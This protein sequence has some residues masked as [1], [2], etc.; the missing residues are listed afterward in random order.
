M[1]KKQEAKLSSMSYEIEYMLIK[2]LQETHQH[3]K[4]LNYKPFLLP[5]LKFSTFFKFSTINTYCL[6]SKKINILKQQVLK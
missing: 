5:S 3:V 4:A 6:Y 1:N 2:T